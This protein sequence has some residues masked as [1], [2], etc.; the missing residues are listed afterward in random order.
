MGPS[1]LLGTG[2]Q[3]GFKEKQCLRL[4]DQKGVKNELKAEAKMKFFR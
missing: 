4:N 2:K 1:F 3:A